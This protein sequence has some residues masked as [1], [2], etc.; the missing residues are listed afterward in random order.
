WFLFTSAS[1]VTFC[2]LFP[3]PAGD[4]VSAGHMLFLLLPFEIIAAINW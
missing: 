2:C 1:R 4:L 3:I